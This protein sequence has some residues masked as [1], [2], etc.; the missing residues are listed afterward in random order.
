MHNDPCAKLPEEALCGQDGNGPRAEGVRDEAVGNQ[1]LLLLLRDNDLEQSLV[2]VEEEVRVTVAEHA[3]CF[4]RHG[5]LLAAPLGQREGLELELALARQLPKHAALLLPFRI[6]LGREV[7]APV[8]RHLQ[9]AGT[10]GAGWLGRQDG[11]GEGRRATASNGLLLLLL[12]IVVVGGV[13]ALLPTA[14]VCGLG[15]FALPLLLRSVSHQ[16]Q[17]STMVDAATLEEI[18]RLK[19]ALRRRPDDSDSDESSI[20][21][22]VTNRGNK[23]KRKAKDVYEGKLGRSLYE[24]E[25]V[26]YANKRRLVIHRHKPAHESEM[27]EMEEAAGDASDDDPYAKVKIEDILA[28]LAHPS[29]LLTH[30][31]YSVP[32]SRHVLRE[33]CAL[34]LDATNLE[35]RHLVAMNKLLARLMGDDTAHLLNKVPPLAPTDQESLRSEALHRPPAQDGEGDL[36]SKPRTRLAAHVQT[37]GLLPPATNEDFDMGQTP[38]EAYETKRLLQ[39]AIQRSQEY[40]RC[41]ERM[42]SGLLKACRLKD[43]VAGWCRDTGGE[44]DDDEEEQSE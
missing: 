15:A 11:V 20:G 5:K 32:Y 27:E 36:L 9:A 38:Q 19:Y 4:C 10:A 33:L 2:L 42:R 35:Q 1:I 14:Q 43:C 12:L 28:P 26:E 24:T 34:S 13:A 31:G 25:Q 17:S 40:V 3:A 41:L 7:L 6:R 8:R 16:P 22:A 30:P 39:A 18:V 37:S 44:D 23:L 29:D 21:N